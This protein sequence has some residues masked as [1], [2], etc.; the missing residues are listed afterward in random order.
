MMRTY[1]IVLGAVLVLMIGSSC[2][3]KKQ[4]ESSMADTKHEMVTRDSGLKYHVL[5]EA[6]AN[7]AHIKP[8]DRATV[9]YTGWLYDANAP[10]FKGNKFDSSV[11]RGQPF[12]FNV[13]AGMVIKGWDEGVGLMKVGEKRR[14]IIPAALGY[15]AYGAGAIIPPNATLVFDVELLKIN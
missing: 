10:E 2:S 14:F 3:G 8:G 4:Q 7:A 5:K 1:G 12:Q 9:H 13:G 15:G 11:D 6:A